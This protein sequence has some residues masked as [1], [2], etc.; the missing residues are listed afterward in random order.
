MMHLTEFPVLIIMD[1]L[2]AAVDLLPVHALRTC[3]VYLSTKR[4]M[5]YTIVPIFYNICIVKN[6]YLHLHNLYNISIILKIRL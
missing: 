4:L 1:T 6:L 5:A 3:I 2:L